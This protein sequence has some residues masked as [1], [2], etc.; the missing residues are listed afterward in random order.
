MLL[1]SAVAAA[2]TATSTAA[3]TTET[4]GSC[5]LV[6]CCRSC[7]SIRA[8]EGLCAR[9]AGHLWR[10]V[11]GRGGHAGSR[12]AII[13][14]PMRKRCRKGIAGF[15]AWET[16]R[17]CMLLRLRQ[18][19]SVKA[20]PYAARFSS[21]ARGAAPD[22]QAPKSSA[23]A[24]PAA[25]GAAVAA[26]AAPHQPAAPPAGVQAQ[27]STTAADMVQ[28]R[29]AAAAE[30][31]EECRLER[32]ISNLQA[33]CSAAPVA[34]AV[35][36]P[37]TVPSCQLVSLLNPSFEVL[38]N[39]TSFGRVDHWVRMLPCSSCRCRASLLPCLCR[40]LR[41]RP[42]GRCMWSSINAAAS[43]THTAVRQCT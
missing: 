26:P 24:G 27:A 2:L 28:T 42:A 15:S 6:L 19:F 23:T 4:G 7:V 17:R 25:A 16:A 36:L 29:R 12:E 9:S 21:L 38:S 3:G 33:S 10:A 11:A 8:A 22:P 18:Y 35:R 37:A 43:S 13:R 32:V 5:L 1:K 41:T 30:L 39:S 14:R 20:A 34:P 31:A 40:S